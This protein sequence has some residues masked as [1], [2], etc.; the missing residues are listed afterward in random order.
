MSRILVVDDEQQFLRL[1]RALLGEAH[2]VDERAPARRVEP[3]GPSR[4]FPWVAME[5]CTSRSA[6]HSFFLP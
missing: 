5:P 3:I 2:T 6:T 1:L 4:V